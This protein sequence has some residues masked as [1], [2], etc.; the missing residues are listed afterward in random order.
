MHAG[1]R[2]AL[3]A[4]AGPVSSERIAAA[5]AHCTALG[6]DP[7]LGASAHER[8]GFLA[9]SDAARAADLIAAWTDPNI[10]AVWAIRGGYGTMRLLD[11]FAA[12]PLERSAKPFIGFSDNTA[13]QMLLHQRGIASFH[14]PHAG[15]DFPPLADACMRHVL[16]DGRAG[17]LPRGEQHV[18]SLIGGTA[19]GPLLGGNLS[20]LAALCGTRYQPRMEG[21][22]L[23]L[24]EIGEPFYRIDRMLVQLE[25]AGVFEGVAGV[26]IGQFTDCRGNED[27]E[28]VEDLLF[29]RFA[30]YGVPLAL[31]FPFGHVA[32][33]WTLPQGVRARMDATAGTLELL[34]SA[35]A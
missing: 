1:S 2:V 32:D 29:D 33:N 10:D 5:R 15:G 19:D 21:C 4:P 25:M 7:V 34:E 28:R 16:I 35:V 20:I 24:E 27:S 8:T 26:I 14:G 18:T 23:F 12:L 11:A 6:M 3:I 30:K 13:L 22:L 17:M 31:G 9:G